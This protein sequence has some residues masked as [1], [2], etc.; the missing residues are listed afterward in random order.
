MTVRILSIFLCIAAVAVA[1]VAA[2]YSSAYLLRRIPI[3]ITES[4]SVKAT[5]SIL[6]FVL[7]TCYLLCAAF[8]YFFLVHKSTLTETTSAPPAPPNVPAQ[9]APLATEL[10]QGRVTAESDRQERHTLLLEEESQLVRARFEHWPLETLPVLPEEKSEQ[11]IVKHPSQPK[12]RE[13][14]KE[15]RQTQHS[16]KDIQNNKNNNARK[17]IFGNMDEGDKE[18]LKTAKKMKENWWWRNPTT[19][20]KY[21]ILL[22]KNSGYCQYIITAS[23]DGRT[24][25]YHEHKLRCR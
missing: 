13:Q 24:Y 15:D 16:V 25:R 9:P 11:V 3:S 7:L 10:P 18:N 2:N 4:D 19:G 12:P 6:F 20:I 8:F 21:E 1:V 22:Q 17:F 5:R 14:K 23:I